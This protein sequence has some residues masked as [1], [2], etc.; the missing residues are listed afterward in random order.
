MKEIVFPHDCILHRGYGN[1][2]VGVERGWR[3]ERRLLRTSIPPPWV[4]VN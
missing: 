2:M 4:K 3:E 1:R